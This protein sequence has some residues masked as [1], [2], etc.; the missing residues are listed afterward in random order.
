MR[1]ATI[2]FAVAALGAGAVQPAAA[3]MMPGTALGQCETNHDMCGGY[4]AGV[5]DQ[6]GGF[7]APKS[8]SKLQKCFPDGVTLTILL[9]VTTDYLTAHPDMMQSPASAVVVAA[10]EN[11]LSC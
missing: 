11:A 5:I 2:A 4:I 6:W 8:L 3:A 9:A 10:M 1:I 7:D